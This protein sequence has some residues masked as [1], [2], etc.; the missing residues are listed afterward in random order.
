[1]VVGSL[2][3][4]LLRLVGGDEAAALVP[5]SVVS[6]DPKKKEEEERGDGGGATGRKGAGAVISGISVPY[7]KWL[8]GPPG[9]RRRAGGGKEGR[10]RERE[11]EEEEEEDK[12]EESLPPGYAFSTPRRDELALTISRTEIPKTEDTLARL[13][14]V[15]VRYTPVPPTSASTSTSTCTTTNP[16]PTP[17]P[18]PT[19]TAPPDPPQQSDL[20]AWA[21]LGPDGSLTSLHVEPAHRGRGLAKAVSRR[22]FRRLADDASAV[23]FRPVAIDDDDDDNGDGD[24]GDD[25]VTGGGWAH[26]DVAVENAGSAGVARGLGGKEGWRVRWV[27]VDLGAV[28]GG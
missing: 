12:E 25:G 14:S 9:R 23:G 19:P 2:N 7:C 6:R 15:G 13:G 3:E 26:S 20:I 27:G 8:I 11:R 18:T 4:V 10:E 5:Q 21:F 28:V 22:L 24:D 16:N 17:T 1:M